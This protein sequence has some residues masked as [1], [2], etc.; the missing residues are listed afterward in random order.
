LIFDSKQV[1]KNFYLPACLL[2]IQIFTRY[3]NDKKEERFT[4]DK[5][6]NE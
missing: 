6:S 5:F 4:R 2:K 3:Q 1:K